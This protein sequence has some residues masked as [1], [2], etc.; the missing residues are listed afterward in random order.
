MKMPTLRAL[1]VW[2]IAGCAAQDAGEDAFA[3]A[4]G[5]GSAGTTA[6]AGSTDAER[7]QTLIV[8]VDRAASAREAAE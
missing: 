1:L 3:T 7:L 2:S 6:A 8:E 4:G 5:G